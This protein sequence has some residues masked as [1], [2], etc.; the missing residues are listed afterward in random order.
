MLA[1]L[2]TLPLIVL[3]MGLG[4]ASMFVPALH[5]LVT[6][7][8]HSARAFF[9]FAILF[10]ILFTLLAIAVSG[11]TIR[12]Q[13]RSH[14][15]ALLATYTIVPVM[16]AVPFYEAVR[17]TTFFNAY[18]EMV[19]ALTTTGATLFVPE[20]LTSTAHLWRAQVGWMGGFFVWV[21]AVAV[22]APMNLGGFE[23]RGN[24]AEIGQ[25]AAGTTQITRVADPSE[26]LARFAGRLFPV[27]GGLTLILWAVLYI[28]GDTPLVAL[29]H[30]MST[31][32]TSGISPIGGTVGA[33]SGFGGEALIFLFLIFGL[34]RLTF[35]SDERAEGAQS[36]WKD[37]EL[38]LGLLLVAIIPVF[39]LLR[40]TV[41]ALELPGSTSF[42][43]VVQTLWGGA[44]TV[45]SFLT[46]TGFESAAWEGAKS[47]SGL[48]T[49]GLILMG[50][51]VFGGGVATTA[52]GVKLLR[53][54][55][56][57]KHGLREMEKLVH[58]HSVGG[59]G[60]TARRTRRQGAY[61][62]WIFFMLFAISIAGVMSAFALAGV[63]FEEALVLTIA[64][65]TTTGPLI[66]A[67]ASEPIALGTAD[68]A[69]RAVFIAAMVVG[70]LETLAIIALLNPDFWRS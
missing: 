57:Y 40:H 12:R 42:L 23:V 41:G 20:R 60:R 65:L 49:P 4:A 24:E 47:W 32:A 46:T 55:A 17:T 39:M 26:R 9:Y 11:T 52:G 29:C 31:M 13:G 18:F 22:L 35:S 1:R 34:S 68:P 19:S 15:L 64:S 58:P 27:Y 44:F 53:V 56:L 45:M 70:R 67:A 2:L 28:L 69:V 25:G 54:H 66:D 48:E 14:L 36:I 33:G 7:D 61:V 59:A 37:E 21:T 51:A 10:L 62:A 63:P 6:D 38:R 5:A 50:L 16:L 43:V 30:A 3:V 8:H